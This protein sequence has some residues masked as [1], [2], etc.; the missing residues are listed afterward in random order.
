MIFRHPPNFFSRF[1]RFPPNFFL[2]FV[3]FHQI[4]FFILPFSTKFSASTV[5]KFATVQKERTYANYAYMGHDGLQRYE[6]TV[7]NSRT[8]QQVRRR[9]FVHI[10]E[11]GV[12]LFTILSPSC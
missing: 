2:D 9:G 8:V 3:I 7:R 6:A 4:F 12:I 5:A 11:L 10:I 1:C